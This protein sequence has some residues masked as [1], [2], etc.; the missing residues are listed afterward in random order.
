MMALLEAR[1]VTKIFHPAPRW[2]ELLLFKRSQPV[3]ALSGV[4][5]TLEPGQ[6]FAL[7]G[8]NG[9]GKSTFLR[10]CSGVLLPS[11]GTLDVDGVSTAADMS[12]L[13]RLVGTMAAD[14]RGLH[15]NLSPQEFLAYVAALY[16][17]ARKAAV[18]VASDQLS[19]VGLAAVA[20]RPIGELSTG[21]R[22]RLQLARAL[23]GAPKLLL[24]DE[25]LRGIDPGSAE[26]LRQ[27]LIDLT[28]AGTAILLATH[29]LEE[30]R[31]LCDRVVLVECGRF[32]EFAPE[33]VREQFLRV[34]HD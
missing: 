27:M 8:K 29:D 33:H 1:S 4:D 28:A 15:L 34:V 13:G 9:A 7:M 25:P 10:L 21:M 19:R 14:E 26:D 18:A 2:R 31:R 6:I 22:R 16:G 20:A 5:L 23:L 30:A 11:S 3:V 24:L 32:S 12:R 17:H